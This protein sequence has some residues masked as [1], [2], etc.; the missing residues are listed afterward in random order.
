MDI[1]VFI[2]GKMHDMKFRNTIKKNLVIAILWYLLLACVASAEWTRQGQNNELNPYIPGLELNISGGIL[3]Y[4]NDSEN[5]FSSESAVD[6]YPPVC[7]GNDPVITSTGKLIL[8]NEYSKYGEDKDY[9][10]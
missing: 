7:D 8:S 1:I 3:Y 5:C 10:N 4:Y 9:A 6:S 2:D